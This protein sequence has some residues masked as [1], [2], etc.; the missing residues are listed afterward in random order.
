[1]KGLLQVNDRVRSCNGARGRVVQVYGRHC[2]VRWNRRFTNAKESIGLPAY[3]RGN[4]I[5]KYVP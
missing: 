3:T 5:I 1:M 4:P 2:T